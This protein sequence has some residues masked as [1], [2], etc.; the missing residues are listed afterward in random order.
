MKIAISIGDL[1]GVGIEIA[2]KAHDEVKKLCHPI[3]MVSQSML[4]KSCE[5]LKRDIP[6]DFETIEVGD[7]FDIKPSYATK[8][9][10]RYAYDS[11]FKALKS[12]EKKETDAIVTLPIN[13]E[14]WGKAGIEFRGHTDLL[15]DYFQKE[16]IMM[17]GCNK[18]FSAFFTH[19]IPLK[20]VAE[21]VKKEPLKKFLLDFYNEVKEEKIGV[22]GLNPHAGDGGVIGDEEEEIK[23]AIKEANDELLEEVFVGPLVP[24]T[25]F[26]PRMIEHINYFVC[27]YHD[28]GLIA[29]KTLFF[30][31]SINVSLNLPI[32]RTSVDHGTAYDIAYMDKNP[33]TLS[34]INAVKEAIKLAQKRKKYI[35]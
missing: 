28:Q 9:S 11:F 23:K 29:V 33:S 1:N 5:L 13:K 3:Y 26:T 31:E 6:N 19:H 35:I 34:Y 12:A 10:G 16:A 14:A 20:D 7:D 24:D 18:L 21:K 27:M 17:I 30:Y 25:A 32:I 4:K 22:L 8:E 15:A 2:L